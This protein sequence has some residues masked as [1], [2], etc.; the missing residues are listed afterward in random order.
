MEQF[1]GLERLFDE[2]DRAFADRCHRR[3][4]IAVARDHQHRQRRI[5]ALDLLEQL[6][7][8]EPRPL[9]PHVEQDQA[10]TAVL[11]RVERARAVGGGADRIAFIF[12]HARDQ[13]ADVGLI[14]DDQYFKRHQSVSS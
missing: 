4:E 7:A 8:V 1:V 14:V 3:V 11:D 6:Q 12:K 5:A 10:R 2:V 9:K 13:F